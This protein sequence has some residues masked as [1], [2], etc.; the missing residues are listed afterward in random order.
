[1]N[2]GG[3]RCLFLFFDF[4]FFFWRFR[5]YYNSE[6]EFFFFFDRLTYLSLISDLSL[7]FHGIIHLQ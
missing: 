7:S 1:M 5:E 3:L 4:R 2:M 6:G